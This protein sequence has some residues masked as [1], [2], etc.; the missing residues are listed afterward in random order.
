[1]Q[2]RIFS[3]CVV[4]FT[5]FDLYAQVTIWYPN[6]LGIEGL[7]PNKQ[8]AGSPMAVAE[9]GEKNLLLPVFITVLK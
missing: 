2:C 4:R 3:C 9:P 1:M 6:S 8:D 5:Q 7:E